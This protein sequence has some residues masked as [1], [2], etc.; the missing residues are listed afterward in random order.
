MRVWQFVSDSW[1]IRLPGLLG[2][3]SPPC[4]HTQPAGSTGSATANQRA[5]STGPIVSPFQAHPTFHTTSL[6]SPAFYSNDHSTV[7]DDKNRKS[8]AVVDL[9]LSVAVGPEGLHLC[10]SVFSSVLLLLG[11]QYNIESE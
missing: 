7:S 5:G 2:P 6:A 9:E 1:P 11:E 10:F 8:H 4:K 3:L